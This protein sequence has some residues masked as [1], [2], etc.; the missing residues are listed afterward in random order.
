MHEI[1]RLPTTART[2]RRGSDTH[3]GQFGSVAV[4]GGAQGMTGA[5]LLAGRAALMLGAGKVWVALLDTRLTVDVQQAELM[6]C[7]A[8]M[9][10][11]QQQASH[12]LAGMG[13]GISPESAEILALVM[14]THLPL[15]LDA[16][17]LN[18]IA[19][20]PALQQQLS[21]RHAPT[22]LTPH[23]SEAARLL[24]TSNASIQQ[25]RLAALRALIARY[26]C[27]IVLKGHG[28]L[29]GSRDGVIT[30]NHSG[31]A[32]LSS[33]GQGDTLAGIIMA[34][35]A[36]GLELADAARCGVYLHGKAADNWL[37]SH[38]AGIGLTASETIMLARQALN[39]EIANL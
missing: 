7:D 16:D 22:I 10:L 34:L 23:P 19:N 5:A 24:G 14:D 29:V 33:A 1:N 30:I 8:R 11:R 35:C 2:L 6:L 32:A 28:T 25:D 21:H 3:K 17:A 18:L 20:E 37:T 38:P 9:V 12:I 4:I 39:V 36:Q 31:N 27:H 26:Q 13:M 15:L